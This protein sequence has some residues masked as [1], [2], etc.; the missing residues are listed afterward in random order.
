MDF[1]NNLITEWA[2][3][4]PEWLFWTILV[5]VAVCVFSMYFF[6]KH[7]RKV[8]DKYDIPFDRVDGIVKM[9]AMLA[10]RL[11]VVRKGVE[12]TDK[13]ARIKNV[14][15]MVDTLYPTESS[16]RLSQL[17]TELEQAAGRKYAGNELLKHTQIVTDIQN[18]ILKE[19]VKVGDKVNDNQHDPFINPHDISKWMQKG[20]DA[21][22]LVKK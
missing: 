13:I 10:V 8:T 1:I 18:N 20:I 19:V 22:D 5:V 15:L 4:L 3:V 14:A 21:V 12:E 7:V 2:G 6:S 9:L 16:V 11:Y 17:V